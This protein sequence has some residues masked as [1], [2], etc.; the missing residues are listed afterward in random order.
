MTE[1]RDTMQT[2]QDGMTL[3]ELMIALAISAILIIGVI[4]VFVNSKR[5]YLVNAQVAAL[6]EDMRFAIHFI[7]QDTRGAGYAGCNPVRVNN[8]LNPAGSGYSN[9]LFDFSTAVDGWEATGTGPGA[10]INLASISA[11]W[12]NMN[13]AGL[14]ASLSGKVRNGSDVL[15][16]HT[17]QV[18]E[19]VFPSG[20]TPPSAATI[21]LNKSSGIKQGT[22]VILSDCG[23]SGSPSA[24]DVFQTTSNTSNALARGVAGGFSPGNLTPASTPLSHPYDTKSQ[25]LTTDT[26]VYYIG[27]GAGG[28]PALFRADYTTGTTAPKIEELVDGVDTLQVLYGEDLTNDLYRTP[29]RYVTAA[30]ITNPANITSVQIG[31][32]LST[33]QQ[34]PR[35][36]DTHTYDL[37]G[38][39][40]ATR[41][42]VTPNADRRVRKAITITIQLRNRSLLLE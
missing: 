21:A 17:A 41:V 1:S 18:V 29:T 32:L 11:G 27:T 7:T 33:P 25:I 14:P 28:R 6:Q 13:G 37:L 8:L 36:N 2:R 30:N 34:L 16:V 31:L 3:I 12:K 9:T 39:T 23:A 22:I 4:T 10:N 40:T 38:A 19:G 35:K 15:V 24:A 20:T 5:T 26:R 42:Q